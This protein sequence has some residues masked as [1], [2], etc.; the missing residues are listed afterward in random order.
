MESVQHQGNMFWKFIVRELEKLRKTKKKKKQQQ[1]QVL[2]TY[3]YQHLELILQPG[4]HR[5]LF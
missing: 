2:K 5:C 4:L 3:N 1:Q